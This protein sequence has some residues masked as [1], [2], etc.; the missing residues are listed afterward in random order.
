[1]T[2]V[3]SV[4]E[5]HTAE[6]SEGL[7]LRGYASTPT[8]DRANDSVNPVALKAAVAKYLAT[9]PV[10]LW[11]HKYTLPAIGRVLDA[12]ID[13]RG[14]YI[15]ALLPRPAENTF[16]WEVYNSVKTGAVR[17]L[18]LG[19]KFFRVP[20]AGYAE[21]NDARID[22]ISLCSQSV[23]FDTLTDSVVPTEVKALG[24]GL[25]VPASATI[26]EQIAARVRHGR[27]RNL[28]SAVDRLSL[29]IGVRLIDAHAARALSRQPL[30]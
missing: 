13:A 3:P 18:S 7:L 24:D 25:W 29:E 1:V 5:L 28:E 19:A 27:V 2:F 10:L 17:A 22:E 30:S 14:V 6:N 9:N 21:I 12:R 26:N 23:G 20:R 11:A 8:I 4:S 15:E 16:A